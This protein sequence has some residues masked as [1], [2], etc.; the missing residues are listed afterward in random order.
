MA[1]RRRELEE[2]QRKEELK[3]QEDAQR[4]K[5]Q[6]KLKE[7]VINSKYLVDNKN[8][9]EEKKKK[10]VEEHK[11][12]LK[13]KKKEYDED[14]QR[15]LQKVYNRPLMFEQDTKT[16]DKLKAARRAKQAIEEDA[17]GENGEF[18]N[19]EMSYVV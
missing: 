1:T 8:K 6:N 7:R 16:V 3:K 11:E 2:K 15:R 17:D 5:N 13:A 9:L 19:E 4:L 14:M 10:K 12:T 18:V